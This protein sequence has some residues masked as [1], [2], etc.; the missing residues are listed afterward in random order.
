MNTHSPLGWVRNVV[1]VNTIVYCRY[2][3]VMWIPLDLYGYHSALRC[4]RIVVQCVFTM[5]CNDSIWIP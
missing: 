2:P 3:R 5:L 4:L 1:H